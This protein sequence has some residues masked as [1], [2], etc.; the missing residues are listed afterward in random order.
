M[1]GKSC[2]SNWLHFAFQQSFLSMSLVKKSFHLLF[3][4]I[5]REFVLQQKQTSGIS[6]LFSSAR[7][8]PKNI[9]CIQ[10]SYPFTNWRICRR[11]FQH[12]NEW[13][14]IVHVNLDQENHHNY[15]CCLFVLSCTIVEVLF[16]SEWSYFNEH[17]VAALSL[18]R[19]KEPSS[20]ILLVYPNN[21]RK[22]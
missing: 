22:L 15:F 9:Q 1:R 18:E 3:S 16:M 7:N 8:W 2:P 13:Y 11:T 21:Q 14:C 17:S 19:K 4:L 12:K 6:V 5:F 20:V 10:F